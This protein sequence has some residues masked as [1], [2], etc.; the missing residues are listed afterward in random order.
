MVD[1]QQV[2]RTG[3]KSVVASQ[4]VQGGAAVGDG[5]DHAGDP[6]RDTGVR[7][8]P[9]RVGGVCLGQLHREHPRVGCC[10][11]DPQRA[12]PAVGAQ[13]QCQCRV[14]PAHRGVEEQAFLVADV[15]QDRLLI[16]E[17]VDRGDDVVEI[18]GAG[19]GEHIVDRGGLPAVADLSRSGDVSHPDRQPP[20]RPAQQRYPY[21]EGHAATVGLPGG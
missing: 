3:G 5:A 14:C 20:D 7:P 4:G 11:G 2:Q 12:V 19:V 17:A 1:E 18:A 8:D 10:T 13:L 15:D 9:A 6:V 21:F 16:G